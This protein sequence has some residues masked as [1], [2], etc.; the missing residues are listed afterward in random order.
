MNYKDAKI[1]T[2]D[3]YIVSGGYRVIN[4]VTEDY[5]SALNEFLNR[6]KHTKPLSGAIIE[7]EHRE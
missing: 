1:K 7:F 6:I 4:T 5:E 3:K 2:Q